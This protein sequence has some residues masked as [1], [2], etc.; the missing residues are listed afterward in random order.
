MSMW[1]DLR[2]G[3]RPE[4]ERRLNFSFLEVAL[5]MAAFGIALTVLYNPDYPVNPEIALNYDLGFIAGCIAVASGTTSVLMHVLWWF[6]WPTLTERFGYMIFAL[7]VLG[8]TLC[9]MGAGLVDRVVDLVT[10]AQ[11][12]TLA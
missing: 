3:E 11:F 6:R 4:P 5:A 10:V 1:D 8:L 9:L 7:G 12:T 2:P